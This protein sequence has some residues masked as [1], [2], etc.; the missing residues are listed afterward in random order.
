[1]ASLHNENNDAIFNSVIIITDRRILDQQLQ[2]TVSSFDHTLGSVVTIDEKKNSG[3][4]RDAINDGKRIIVTT[5]QKF[6]VIY[7]EVKSAVGKHYAVIV[8]EAHSS[9]TG[10]SALKLK[11]A[12]ADVSDALAEY[13]ELE[14]KAIEE[15][16]ANDIL[17]QEMLSQGK[18]SNMS[19]CLYCNAQRQNPGNFRRTSIGWF[20][21]SLPH[22]FDATGYRRRIYP[23]CFSELYHIQNVLSNRKE[24]PGQSGSPYL[25]GC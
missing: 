12:L 1:M 25:Q 15:V 13:A 7:N 21:P 6:P 17:V 10:Q 22:L 11:A 14:E 8:D 4:L 9:Q 3:A 24:C 20:F 2:A 16:E 18:H 5:L 19:F 23:G